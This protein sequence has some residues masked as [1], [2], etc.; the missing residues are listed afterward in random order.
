MLQS[1]ISN[2]GL[3]VAAVSLPFR[4]IEMWTICVKP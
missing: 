1:A 3:T 2:Q 4:V